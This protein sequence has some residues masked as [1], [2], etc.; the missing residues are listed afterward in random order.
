MTTLCH[1]QY[2]QRRDAQ[3]YDKKGKP[4]IFQEGDLVLRKILLFK[5][6]PYGKFRPNF[7]I[8]YV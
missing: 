1:G 3:A 6:D 8:P 5:E 2:Y 4:R 7:E